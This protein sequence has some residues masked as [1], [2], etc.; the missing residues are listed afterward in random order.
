MAETIRAGEVT[1]EQL[2]W[3]IENSGEVC[4]RCECVQFEIVYDWSRGR[5]MHETR[6]CAD[7]DLI[8][9]LVYKIVD[10]SIEPA[11]IEGDGGSDE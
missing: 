3:C 11:L 8:V 10:I 5:Y 1:E 7:C 2:E 6:Q 9:S 4:P